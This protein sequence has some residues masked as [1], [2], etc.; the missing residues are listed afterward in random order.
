MY[1]NPLLWLG[2][3][4]PS[5]DAQIIFYTIDKKFTAYK[6]SYCVK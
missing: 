2:Y 6:Q 4:L 5:E 1:K 3:L